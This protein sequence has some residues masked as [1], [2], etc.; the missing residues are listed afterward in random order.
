MDK[1]KRVPWPKP[2]LNRSEPPSDVA[3]EGMDSSGS[4]LLFFSD[5][6]D[7]DEMEEI[8]ELLARRDKADR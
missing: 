4:N 1:K 3:A 6:L 8:R 7:E 2:D 5:F